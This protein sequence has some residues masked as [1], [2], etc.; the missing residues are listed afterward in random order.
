MAKYVSHPFIL[1]ECQIKSLVDA[2]QAKEP[3]VLR[4]KVPSFVNGNINLPLSKNEA[5]SVSKNKAFYYS[6]NKSKIKLMKISEGG[7]FPLIPLILGGITAL[8][9]LTGGASSIAKTVL[10]NKINNEKL[11]EEKRYH[12]ELLKGEGLYLNPWKAGEGMK[13]FVNSSNLDP[14]G[15]KTLRSIFKNLSKNFKIERQG[16]GLYLSSIYQ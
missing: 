8:G 9:A 6:F 14:V 11:A 7:I 1:T 3:L 4:L 15:K 2:I 10:D 13:E 5:L 16:Q 12:D